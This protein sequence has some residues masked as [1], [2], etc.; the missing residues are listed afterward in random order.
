MSDSDSRVAWSRF[1]EVVKAGGS[2]PAPDP[3]RPRTCGAAAISC[4][5]FRHSVAATFPFGGHRIDAEA[6]RE[7]LRAAS[8]AD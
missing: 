4:R 7:Q 3:A 5:R 2:L 1:T 6:F 8:A